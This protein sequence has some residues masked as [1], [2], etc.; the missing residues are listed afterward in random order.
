MRSP[1]SGMR[2]PHHTRLGLGAPA[3]FAALLL[4][5][6]GAGVALGQDGPVINEFMADNSTTL[7]NSLGKC[8]DWIEL[9]N[10]SSTNV[11]LKGWYL[12]DD[13]GNLTKWKFPTNS[14]SSIAGKG[15]L[16]V[17]ADSKSYSVTNNE[18]HAS[19][20]LDKDG[21][22]LALVK[23]DGVTVVSEFQPLPQYQDMSYGIGANGEQRYFAVPT[24]G[25]TNAFA[26]ASNEV[27]DTEFTP[28]SGFYSNAVAV[29]ITCATAGAEIRYTTDCGEPTTNSLLYTSPIPVTNTTVLR[30]VAFKSGYAP[31]DIDTH[32]YIFPAQAIRQ[33][34][35]PSGFPTNW[36]G[37]DG[38][39]YV[40]DYAMDPVIVTNPAYAPFMTNAL[41][42][43][44]SVSIVTTLSNLFDRTNGIYVN[45]T[46]DGWERPATAEWLTTNNTTLFKAD[47][48]LRI[49]GGAMRP[50]GSAR[51]K[52][53][54]LVFQSEFGPSKLECD[55]FDD[56][57][58]AKSFDNL[59]LRA[60]SQDSWLSGGGALWIQNTFVP[61]T[62]LAMGWPSEHETYAHLYLNGLYWGLY[63][64]I[65]RGDESFAETYYGGDKTNWSV[66]TKEGWQP[67]S[68]LTAWNAMTA[69][70]N[71]GLADNAA[72]QK[73]QGNNP[74][75]T[76]NPAYPVYLDILCHIDYHILEHWIGI[77]DWHRIVMCNR[78]AASSGFRFPVWDSDYSLTDVAV[79]RTGDGMAGYYALLENAEYR[80][81]F[82]DRIYRHMFNGG[83]LTTTQ[84]LP[85]FRELA[86][87]LDPALLGESARWGDQANNGS[88]YT[89]DNWRAVTNSA[90]TVFL[91]H[92]TAYVIPQYRQIGLYPSI[93]PPFFNQQG[94]AFANG[95]PLT[96]TS[97]NAVYY[98]L[99][100]TD[101]REY[102]T[103]NPTGLFYTD[104][105][106]LSYSV[107]VK[108]RARSS[109][110]EWS[111]LNEAL[112]V[113]SSTAPQLRITEVMYHPRKPTGT[114]T[115]GG[116]NEDDFQFIELLN[117]GEEP[118]GLA[119][120][121]LTDGG[122]FDFSDGAVSR[123]LPGEYAVVVKNKTAFTNRYAA[124]MPIKIAGEFK[125]VFDFPRSELSHNGETVTLK[126]ATNGVMAKFTYG[127]G[128][129]WPAAADGAGHSLVPLPTMIADQA[130]GAL[131][132]GGNW[133]ASAYRDGSPGRADPNPVTDVVL[134]EIMA[135]TDFTNA[136][137]SND[138]IE[139]YNTKTS[140]VSFATN[141]YLSDDPEDLKKWMIPGTNS[142]AATNWI[143]FFEQTGFH[144]PTNVGFGLSKGGDAVYLSY[145]AGGTNDR[146]V[147]G[148]RFKA[149]ANFRTW[150]R[151]PDGSSSWY[152]TLPTT[153]K[154]NALAANTVVINEIM[155]H[156]ATNA[157]YP[158]DN[159]DIEYVE[160]YNPGGGAVT[161][162][163]EGGACR[164]SSGVS[165]LF[166]TNT[167]IPAGGYLTLVSFDPST[168]SAARA[169]FLA[170][171]GLTNGQVRLMGPYS[172]RLSDGGDRVAVEF[173]LLGDLPGEGISWVVMDEVYYSDR[174]PWP[175]T[176]D[177]AGTSLNRLQTG[178]SGNDPANWMGASPS[179][180]TSN[181]VSAATPVPVVSVTS[182]SVPEGGTNTFKVWLSAEPAGNATVTVSRVSGDA[183]I[184]VQSGASLVFTSGNATQ[185]VTLAATPDANA[186]DGVATFVCAIANGAS[187][188]VA[189]TEV[190]RDVWVTLTGAGLLGTVSPSE[191]VAV[192]N[193]GAVVISA[194]AN[195]G[196][197]F[198][199]WSV[200]SG[201]ATIA[202]PN[203]TTTSVRVFG[204]A[205]LAANFTVDVFT[206]SMAVPTNRMAVL[207][208]ALTIQ[209]T[210]F[211]S[212][213]ACTVAS[214]EFYANGVKFGAVTSAPYSCQWTPATT[215]MYALAARAIDNLGRTCVSATED[216][217]VVDQ[218]GGTAIGGTATNYT[219]NGTNFT[220]HVF[221]NSG[222]LVASSGVG[223][224]V[225]LVAGGGGGGGGYEGGGGG[226]GGVRLWSGAMGGAYKI[227]VGAGGNGAFFGGNVGANG[228]PSS[229]VG[230]GVS[231]GA[232]GGGRGSAELSGLPYSKYGYSGAAGGSG[233]GGG[234]GGSLT[235][236]SAVGGG[237]LGNSGGNSTSP[238]GY[239]CGGGGG[240][241][242]PG[243][244]ATVANTPGT[245]GVGIAVSYLGTPV[246]YAAGGNGGWRNPTTPFNGTSGGTN[247]GNG[248]S[249]GG[250]NATCI[251]GNGGSGIVIVRYVTVAATNIYT[252]AYDA[253][254]ANSGNAPATQS[255]TQNVAMAVSGNSG[256]LAKTGHTFAGWNT[257]TNGTGANYAPG[258]NYPW[259]ASV[260]LYAKW[261]ANT[262]PTITAQPIGATVYAGLTATF[263]VTA[264]GIAPLFYQWYTNNAAI[265]GAAGT[266]YITP[267]TTTN[268][269]GK[270]FKVTVSNS[271]GA[272]TSSVAT[273]T[274]NAAPTG[275]VA[276]TG[277]VIT[278]HRENGTN[279]IAHIFTNSSAFTL[280][281]SM[282]VQ[283]LVVAGGGGGGGGYQG[284]G[285]GA[286]GLRVG[287]T[288]LPAGTYTI[289]VGTGGNGCRWD[290]SGQGSNGLPSSISTGGVT[291]AS[292][293]GGGR[294]AS[295]SPTYGSAA[296]GSGGGG[297]S[298]G[299]DQYGS[300]GTL[301]EGNA[302]GNAFSTVVQGGGGGAGDVGQTG[303]QGGT[304]GVGIAV[305]YS[306][307]QVAYATGG[308]G[309]KRYDSVTDGAG[310]AAN[311]GNGGHAGGGSAGTGR[312][313]N[314]GSGI[315][316]V[317][318]V[319]AGAFAASVT[320]TAGTAQWP[321]QVG[322]FTIARPA[323][324]NT[325]YD[326]VVN[327]TMSGTATNGVDY[328]ANSVTNGPT[329]YPSPTP[330]PLSGYVTFGV[331][332]TSV[333][334]S[335]Y[336]L[337]NPS[338][339]AKTATM[340]LNVPGDAAANVNFPAWSAGTRVVATGGGVLT[341]Y[342]ENGTNFDARIFTNSAASDTLTLTNGGT[343]EYL[344][345]AGGGGGGGG[346]NGGGGGAGGVCFGWMTLPAGSYTVTVG[347]G[348]PGANRLGSYVWGSN[349]MP[350]VISA[351]VGIISAT[352]GGRGFSE[353]PTYG[354]SS[355][356]SGGGAGSATGYGTAVGG[357]ELGNN[358]GGAANY[359]QGGG[360]GARTVGGTGAN[361]VQGL[362]G[363]G[364]NLTFS[365]VSI[366]YA[367]GGYGCAG[368][369][370]RDGTNGLAN[371]GNGGGGGD[372]ATARMGGNGGSGI[373]IVRYVVAIVP[374]APTGLTAT[375]AATN[376]INLAWADNA[377]DETG[378]VVERSL[379]SNAWSRIVL[380]G[381]NATNVS[382]SGLATNTLYYYRVAAS[383]A[384][385]VSAYGYASATTW[386]VY[387]A[388]RHA[389]FTTEQLTNAVVSGADADPDHDGLNNA[390]EFWAGTDPTN[391]ASVLAL[392]MAAAVPG[393]LGFVVRWQSASNKFYTLQAATNLVAPGFTNRATSIPAT[394]MLNVY[395]DTV[396]SA[397]QIFYRVKLE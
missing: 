327:Y 240:A 372:G 137:D 100:G 46:Q 223:V 309:C 342:N 94:G 158:V 235:G 87:M 203:G 204:P 290:G 145:L 60:G 200:V 373:V 374:A 113:K 192:T 388:W 360:G 218:D 391:A 211:S 269:S 196:Y 157:S 369:V 221:T 314:G 17:W 180:G 57:T 86:A 241:G 371:T 106:P 305:S 119:G 263:G 173:P 252:V 258:A 150:G 280:N 93:D 310:P 124:L 359:W 316:I 368:R 42:A 205:T 345:I 275:T 325:N 237:E 7:T 326:A 277:G 246:T 164:L 389:S 68:D 386:S 4:G 341:N 96:M 107:K 18:L 153:N 70:C 16:L 79:N 363:G 392:S 194:Q 348:G 288:R 121:R 324:A 343:V 361:P 22:Y 61:R 178:R 383:N 328:S 103:G 27:A 181:T 76:R 101:P 394:P 141:W 131:D 56:P 376:Q 140:A 332:V 247:T 19:F 321:V 315:V 155:Y 396:D 163:N 167:T 378:Y 112:F 85:R 78:D 284:G 55:L 115:N 188:A 184:T 291:I 382:D 349:G 274:V 10:P 136:W 300:D 350:S 202:D 148:V 210:T 244:A 330:T 59:V 231:I 132:Y 69:L 28:D 201:S 21:E 88:R 292:A 261:M 116:W 11:S 122:S 370:G 151:Y 191:P 331:G 308:N 175:E 41:L 253:N 245:G 340:T 257:A 375:T 208:T 379:N 80:L 29:T 160:L 38:V 147:D 183:N 303:S 322:A 3:I 339:S 98:T 287:S 109:A 251:G 250:G 82:A 395:T 216:V 272:V 40:A 47:C 62:Q 130:N 256:N 317:R 176:A 118:V 270:T 234:H 159:G 190:D 271:Y 142:V 259:N 120:M 161:L 273:L 236:G 129:D 239:P 23:T 356:G 165:F 249:G 248:G 262:P 20:S 299:V 149:Q 352:G 13:A 111:A 230:P 1:Q 156:P 54:R 6:L 334:V 24:P 36:V 197:A 186:A 73:I 344:V 162:T 108:A 254:G 25:R 77:G 228:M 144:S 302:G 294:G 45:P 224:E 222:L 154:A 83:A 206:C 185:T 126:D 289:T 66:Q 213:R 50:M 362:G 347:A 329:G 110:G 242:G 117:T 243:G 58:A 312:G 166:P 301:G 297:G 125:R 266:T 92:R 226:A 52:A 139:F 311:T 15:F 8:D 32:T 48:G 123:L 318:Y 267:A 182:L 193:G 177:G 12:T 282:N 65:E 84:T 220:A 212:P 169:S 283:Y 296:G 357:G 265:G 281:S 114:E 351:T 170:S 358:G 367:K 199:T 63:N 90:T 33:P 172:G 306:G 102:G 138:W 179:P 233:G 5:G 49:Q 346:W 128:R 51:K 355:G 276:G 293:T 99:D 278:R 333:V 225:L 353:S 381:M 39:N 384:A 298:G 97:T 229:I 53:L 380:T 152:T 320:A 238:L 135:H 319:E 30:A 95:F 37:L 255:K 104:A 171:Y 34:T 209:A 365:G 67:G 189:V 127:D 227:T 9:Y 105:V 354:A 71:A 286:G 323:D 285:G 295:E 313:G 377:T 364:T 35:K 207:E 268:D 174:L 390:Q 195:P 64:P 143:T 187:M 393:G 72:Y 91:P 146:V 260:T 338:T 336:P 337:H 307:V 44:P 26:G 335:L 89:I 133:R 387:E 75:R 279:F 2:D 219:L 134:N 81:L 366:E 397:L 385:G 74:D 14:I 31:S 217:A 214:M 264:S 168:N 43:L 198:T 304:G 232:T 215:G